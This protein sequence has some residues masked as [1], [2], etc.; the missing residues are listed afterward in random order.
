MRQQ[1][2]TH[3]VWINRY[4]SHINLLKRAKN[5]LVL[6]FSCGL[7]PLIPHKKTH[8]NGLSSVCVCEDRYHLDLSAAYEGLMGYWK[9]WSRASV[10]EFKYSCLVN[11]HWQKTTL[12]SVLFRR[13]LATGIRIIVINCLFLP[14]KCQRNLKKRK[15][16][17]KKKTITNRGAHLLFCPTN[18]HSSIKLQACLRPVR[19]NDFCKEMQAKKRTWLKFCHFQIVFEMDKIIAVITLQSIKVTLLCFGVKLSDP[20]H[21]IL[22]F[23][24]IV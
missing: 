19:T 7:L 15:R 10:P 2:T 21:K 16:K 13:F 6:S 3:T 12:V 8:I 4:H 17:R 22:G 18:H 20:F 24:F 1:L 14:I 9:L 11:A 23:Y 5:H